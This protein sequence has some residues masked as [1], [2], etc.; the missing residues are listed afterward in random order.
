MNKA[1][2]NGPFEAKQMG[3]EKGT[4]ASYLS[5]VT[6]KSLPKAIPWYLMGDIG[7]ENRVR[8][9]YQRAC[10]RLDFLRTSGNIVHQNS[11]L[12]EY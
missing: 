9:V 5:H 10:W 4:L 2:I 8:N 1:S 7:R 11:C 6:V 12:D 3:R